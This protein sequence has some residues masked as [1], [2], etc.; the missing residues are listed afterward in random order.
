MANGSVEPIGEARL[1]D[2]ARS[3]IEAARSDP[4]LGR[5]RGAIVADF[6][7]S[8]EETERVHTLGVWGLHE[9]TRS[10]EREEQ[11]LGTSRTDSDIPPTSL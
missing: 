1:G 5:R 8:M 7:D 3:Q 2:F 9:L 10:L 4:R 11:R 6:W